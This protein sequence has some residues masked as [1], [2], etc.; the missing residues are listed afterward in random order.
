MIYITGDCHGD[1]RKLSNKNFPEARELTKND[2]VIVCGDFGY[3][4]DD[5]EQRYWFNWLNERPFTTL[6]VDGNHE[7]FD[8]LCK[9]KV[10]IWN[11]GKVHKISESIIH[12]MR[13]Q[14]FSIGDNLLFTF[15]GAQTHDIKDGILD[16]EDKSFKAKKRQLTKNNAQF[17]INHVSWWKEELPS[18]RELDEGIINLSRV[19]WQVDYIITHCASNTVQKKLSSN[20]TRNR[21]TAYFEIV[22]NTCKYNKWLF[23]HY[24]KDEQVTSNDICIYN[25]LIK[26]S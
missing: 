7:N 15:G 5:K 24:H 21:L 26:L 17:R 18:D 4:S 11:G 20:N 14:V 25:N 23:G 3:W 12:L 22:R 2:Y 19:N 16:P 13:G 8:E 9:L 1:Y 10:S 6:F